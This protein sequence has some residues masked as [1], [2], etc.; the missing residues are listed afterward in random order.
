MRALLEDAGLGAHVEVASA[1]THGYHIGEP[2][3]SRTQKAALRRGYDLSAQRGR[4]VAPADF[5]HFDH[6]LA[7]DAGHLHLL[8]RICPPEHQGK[9]SLFLDRE[10]PDPYYGGAKEFEL[11][12]DLAEEGARVWIARL[13]P[14]DH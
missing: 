1:G 9:L 4:K 7:M 11:V 3:D 5:A 14:S 13:A 12:L 2:P 6:V 8:R 10:V